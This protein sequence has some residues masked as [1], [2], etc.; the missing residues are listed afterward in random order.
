VNKKAVLSDVEID[1]YTRILTLSALFDDDF[2]IDWLLDLTREKASQVFAALEYGVKKKW[3]TGKDNG[4]FRFIDCSEKQKLKDRLQVGEAA[5]MHSQ[6]VN[7]FLD[8]LSDEP[9]KVRM[10][11]PHLLHVANDLDGCRLLI[12]GGNFYQRSFLYDDARQYYEK[13]IEDLRRLQGDEVDNLFINAALQYSKVCRDKIGT[14]ATITILNEAMKLAEK[15]NLK[16]YLALLEM[17]I[18]KNEWL[19]NRYRISRLH[20]NRGW[21]LAGDSDDPRIQRAAA[22]FNMFFH[23]WL[24]RYRDTVRSYEMFAPDVEYFPM[25]NTPLLAAL[26]AGA[27]YSFCGQSSQGMGMLDAVR[28][29]SRKIGNTYIA[30]HAEVAIG[31]I[32]MELNHFEESRKHFEQSLKET[33][34]SH[35]LFAYIGGLVCLSYVFYM[36]N[37]YKKAISAFK[38]FVELTQ[39]AQM[40]MRQGSVIMHLCWAMEEGKL[41]RYK[42]FQLREEI[43]L[44]LQGDHVFT[45]GLALR[46]RALLGKRDGVSGDLV[47]N[48]LQRS[49]KYLEESGHQIQLANARVDLAREYILLGNEKR[50]RKLAEPAV[51]ILSSLN[52]DLVPRDIQPL[53][54]DVRSGENLLEEI[55]RLGQE[56]V[57]IRDN[58]DLFRRIISTVNRVTGAER[59]AIFLEDDQEPRGIM[60]RAAK[61]LTS[62]DVTMPGFEKSMQLIRETLK[63]GKGRIMNFD[64]RKNCTPFE[65]A[66][67]LSCICVPMI[68]RGKVIGVLYHD[69]RLFHSAFREEDLGVLNYFA[70]QAAIAM[71]ITQAWKA[72]Q[73]L[74]DKQQREKEY[75]QGQYLQS[76]HFED[77]VGESPGIINVFK[78]V[79]KVA[80][81]D[82]TVMITGETGV[83]KELVA[84]LIHKHSPRRDKPFISVHC[85]AF[86]ESLIS[87]ELFGHEKGAFTDAKAKQIG[88]FE[89]ANGGTLFLDEIGDISMEIQVKLLRVLQTGEFERVGGEET[90]RSDFRLL[91][92]TN[93]DLE[94]EV[95]TG[96]FRQDLYYRLNVFPIN[97]PPL[98]K[99]KDDIPLLVHYFLESFAAKFTTPVE[100]VTKQ[101][102][103]K[104]MAYDWPGN[105]RELQNVLERAVI[106]S[107][108]VNFRVPELGVGHMISTSD[109]VKRFVSLEEHERNYILSILQETGGKIAGPG[110]AAAVLNIHQNTLKSRMKKLGIKRQTKTFSQGD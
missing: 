86:S 10:I 54:T 35:N 47:I 89:L 41:P 48:D 30:G 96:R 90:I 13:T 93:R 88:R 59:G 19:R 68:I 109:S 33:Q 49:I 63:S 73:D 75:Y 78:D 16:G 94:Q 97:V 83:G 106:L 105:V 46:Y 34:A 26:T 51:K 100:R 8:K 60:L 110:G 95:K 98:R 79:E 6:I 43:K 28:L 20:Y 22:V 107:K 104:L 36:L 58:K 69:N 74:H 15:R 40:P 18:A 85:S 14:D 53:I 11:T 101:E 27:C 7:L 99:R 4:F 2:N 72:M 70:T 24:G 76:V 55:L 17:H 12:E 42:D 62:E 32:F 1:R 45:K 65:Y 25:D 91:T 37:D 31:E 67:I 39:R 9:D 52:E 71:E 3:L 80:G 81:T 38:E 50:A 102:M 29:H 66:K 77:F 82:A 92:A 61:S 103:Q 87:T 57:T 23:Y 21:A 56:L 5:Q 84:R 44:A 64:D 108:G